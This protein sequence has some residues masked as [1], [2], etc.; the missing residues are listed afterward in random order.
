M[1]GVVWA[2]WKAVADREKKMIHE[3]EI[4]RSYLY[5]KREDVISN[6]KRWAFAY[7]DQSL[8]LRHRDVRVQPLAGIY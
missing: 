2:G 1:L 7:R 8:H 4:L 3:G 6:Q 5:F